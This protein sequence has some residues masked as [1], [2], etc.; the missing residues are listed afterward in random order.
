MSI[1]QLLLG[2]MGVTGGGVNALRGESNVQ[3]STDHCLLFHILP[4]YLKTPKASQPTLAAYNTKYTPATKEDHS[5]NW[6][7]NYPKYSA[8]LLRSH[9]SSDCSLEESYTYLPKLDDG[10]NYSWLSL[11]DQMYKGN[12]SGFFAWGQNP[13]CSGANANLVREALGKL[14]WM[15]NKR[16]R[17][18]V[19]HTVQHVMVHFSKTRN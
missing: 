6:W 12:F 1:I 14:D 5:L 18:R 9:Y 3:G 7:K 15:V 11:F 19:S 13:A 8:S 16:L 2:N 17:V 4:G 10:V